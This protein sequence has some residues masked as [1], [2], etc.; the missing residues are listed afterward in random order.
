MHDI[1]SV[2]LCSSSLSADIDEC[3]VRSHTCG[4]GFDCVNTDGSFRCAARPRCPAGFDQ[5]PQGHC[6][7]EW[8]GPSGAIRTH[9]QLDRYS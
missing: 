1:L 6:V 7:G 9:K 2:F 5:D 4:H 8:G 3:L